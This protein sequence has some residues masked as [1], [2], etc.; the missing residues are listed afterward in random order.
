LKLWLPQ[1]KLIFLQYCQ[2]FI[3]GWQQKKNINYL[4]FIL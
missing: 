2:L 1:Y 4:N 3:L